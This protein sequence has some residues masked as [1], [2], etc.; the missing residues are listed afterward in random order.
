MTVLLSR[1][2]VNRHSTVP[3]L[4]EV[5]STHLPTP[6][7][8][9]PG[10][11]STGPADPK[12]T[13]GLSQ[14]SVG[15]LGF[16]FPTITSGVISSHTKLTKSESDRPL[17]YL[18]IFEFSYKTLLFRPRAIQCGPERPEP[19]RAIPSRPEPSRAVPLH[20]LAPRSAA[21]ALPI[22]RSLAFGVWKVLLAK[23]DVLV[24]SGSGTVYGLP[25]GR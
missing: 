20:Y 10:R 1:Q 19:S 21:R 15:L 25:Y 2:F 8:T 13:L 7:M 18:A 16:R 4:L 5:G 24:G 11:A 3:Q 14:S 17:R 23:A 12:T 6:H 9:D 22:S